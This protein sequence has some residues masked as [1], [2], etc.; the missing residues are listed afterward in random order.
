MSRDIEQQLSNIH[1][2]INS[3]ATNGID[4]NVNV[5]DGLDEVKKEMDRGVPLDDLADIHFREYIKYYKEL[6]RYQELVRRR[7]MREAR[8]IADAEEKAAKKQK[9]DKK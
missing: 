7:K 1:W 8:Q 5:K 4:V 2:E 9:T 3:I 6:L